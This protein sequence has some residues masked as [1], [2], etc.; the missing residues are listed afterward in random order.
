MFFKNNIKEDLKNKIGVLEEENRSM[1][2]KIKEY[3]RMVEII[4]SIQSDTEAYRN[5]C[6]EIIYLNNRDVL[7]NLDDI[8]NEK[9]CLLAASEMDEYIKKII[10]E[11]RAA[12][13][14]YKELHHLFKQLIEKYI[15]F[16]MLYGMNRKDAISI[17]EDPQK[18]FEYVMSH[19]NIGGTSAVNHYICDLA[20]NKDFDDFSEEEM[21]IISAS[22]E[23]RKPLQNSSNGKPMISNNNTAQNDTS[24]LIKNKPTV[25]FSKQEEK[26]LREMSE[27]LDQ[28]ELAV[29]EAIGG[30]GLSQRKLIVEEVLYIIDNSSKSTKVNATIKSMSE[31]DDNIIKIDKIKVPSKGNVDIIQLGKNGVKLYEYNFR[32]SPI[33]SEAHLI[34]S[35]HDNI[36]HGYGILF[37]SEALLKCGRY[38]KVSTMNKDKGIEVT[39]NN[40]KTVYVPDLICVNSEGE[41]DYY[42]YELDNHNNKNFCIKCDKMMQVTDTLRFV[43]PNKTV[44][45]ALNRKIETWLAG[46]S[47]YILRNTYIL[48]YSYNSLVDENKAL[49]EYNLSVST[50]PVKNI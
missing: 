44:A 36:K 26:L 16:L 31:A 13:S 47:K 38:S 25:K 30:L 40:K 45:E 32:E 49:I 4:K 3:D 33:E 28:I 21:E 46:K 29:I 11:N 35:E 12:V 39:I 15:Y 14:K 1:N 8:S 22:N 43:V 42:E 23:E 7:P 27:K 34:I 20:K 6:Y 19:K 10:D 18:M 37:L 41:V 5:L 9:L 24:R 17:V 50:A 2:N 48:I